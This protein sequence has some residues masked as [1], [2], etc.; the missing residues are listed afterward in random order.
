M[1]KARDFAAGFA[2]AFMLAIASDGLAESVR[3]SA[4]NCRGEGYE[5]P[6]GGTA[7]A[8]GVK[9]FWNTDD[10]R[11]NPLYCPHNSSVSFPLT[12]VERVLLQVHLPEAQTQSWNGGAKACVSWSY[13]SG[14]TS[15]YTA[16]CDD[17]VEWS[18]TASGGLEMTL[19]NTAFDLDQ[20]HD[21]PAGF[22]YIV[23]YPGGTPGN[24][25]NPSSEISSA[26]V[27]G[28]KVLDN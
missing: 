7:V 5:S 16:A 12:D 2:V 22:P 9:T 8:T 6:S 10:A 19:S 1:K 20:W 14:G 24:I 23:V 17:L 27:V 26:T 13:T 11:Y 18:P 25:H 3:Y 4:F 28:Y 21:H 15:Y